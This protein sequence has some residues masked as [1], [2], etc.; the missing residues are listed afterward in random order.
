MNIFITGVGGFIGFS[1]AKQLLESN[2]KV[3]GIDNLDTYYSS[4]YKKNRI[5]KIKSYKNFT[6][7][8]MD[9][10]NKK[11]LKKIFSSKKI[12]VV[13]HFAAQAGV[14]YSL[15]NP[16][17]YINSNVNGFFNLIE[18]CRTY[19]IK[20]I[21][22]SSSSSIYG[23]PKR[24]PVKET[25][26]LNPINIYGLTKKFNEELADIYSKTYKMNFVGLRFFTVYGPW[27]RPD[28]FI[29][30]LLKCAKQNK[31]FELNNFGKHQRDFTFIDDVVNI[32]K[33]LINK[34]I[35]SQNQKF[36]ICSGNS[37]GLNKILHEISKYTK[38]PRIIKIK[39]NMSDVKKTHGS[40]KKIAKYLKLENTINYKIG[41]KKTVE[42]YNAN[43]HSSKV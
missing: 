36:N 18:N 20:K 13:I 32:I 14:R 38:L 27:G 21:I 23:E 22:Y 41:I 43:Y 25:D 34:K 26:N 10:N 40:N 5:K 15:K 6:F 24:F 19:K 29:F 30:K 28:M 35:Y 8:K 2:H 12:K 16:T 31:F 11:R 39:R 7:Y 42:W 4:I 33:K 37:I 1:L 17:K 3:I 9:L